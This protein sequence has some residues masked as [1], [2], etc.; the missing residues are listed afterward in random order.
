[1]ASDKQIS[2]ENGGNGDAGGA[3]EL[4]TCLDS[5]IKKPI[6]SGRM[7]RIEKR[8]RAKSGLSRKGLI[9]AGVIL[10]LLLIFLI[11]VIVLA[12]CWPRPPHAHQ[13]P[14]CRTPACLSA[15]AQVSYQILIATHPLNIRI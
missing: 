7:A 9:A 8:L 3:T 10:L 15:S 13:F 4:D 6:D 14:I 11:V 5:E 12:A 2:R 1:M